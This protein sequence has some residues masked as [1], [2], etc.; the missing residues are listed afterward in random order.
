M[1][2]FTTKLLEEQIG[3]ILEHTHFMQYEGKH[4]ALEEQSSVFDYR[5]SIFQSNPYAKQPAFR[6]I[7]NGS[8]ALL[9]Y[10]NIT[11]TNEQTQIS[12]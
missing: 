3:S 1:A 6:K 7:D 2:K 4:R 12:I 5:F 10:P 11:K 8:E 9:Y